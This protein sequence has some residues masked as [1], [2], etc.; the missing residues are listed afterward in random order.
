MTRIQMIKLRSSALFASVVLSCLAA[1]LGA[2]NLQG[3]TWSEQKCVLYGQAVEDA[4]GLQGMDGL[5]D[6]FLTE[7]QSFL[8]GGCQTPGQVCPITDAELKLANLLT[9]MTMNEGMASTFVPF[10]CP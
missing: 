4:L 5:R 10:R 7:N 3:L 9:R 1:P 2:Q 6:V 8:D